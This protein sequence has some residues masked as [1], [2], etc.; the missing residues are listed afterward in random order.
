MSDA[1]RRTLLAAYYLTETVSIMLAIEKLAEAGDEAAKARLT[2][3]MADAVDAGSR[4]R[5]MSGRPKARSLGRLN[6]E[7]RMY[8]TEHARE[9]DSILA[10]RKYIEMEDLHFVDPPMLSSYDWQAVSKKLRDNPG[11]WAQLGDHPIPMSVINAVRQGSVTALR[12]TD[13]F[14]VRS[15]AITT[16]DEGVRVANLFL[17]YD[18][19]EVQ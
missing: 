17:K 13:G 4:W 9:L 6:E 8:V 19:P 10:G 7:A 14:K 16:D 11:R 18:D 5:R 15:R 3:V 1:D 2:E 12:P